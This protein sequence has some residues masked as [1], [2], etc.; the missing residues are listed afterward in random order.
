MKIKNLYYSCAIII[1]YYLCALL[2]ICSNT[3]IVVVVQESW[4]FYCALLASP[5]HQV[6]VSLNQEKYN[7]L[8]GFFWDFLDF[9]AILFECFLTSTCRW[10]F[11]LQLLTDVSKNSHGTKFLRLLCIMHRHDRYDDIIT[12][13]PHIRYI[14]IRLKVKLSCYSC[15]IIFLKSKCFIFCT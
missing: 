5:R 8:C 10:L 9:L 4:R 12:P 2:V 15:I 13:H 11:S 6:Y 7:M 14:G 3:I 1:I